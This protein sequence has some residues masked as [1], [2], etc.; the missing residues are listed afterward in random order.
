MSVLP[1]KADL[2]EHAR[3]VRF[4]PKGTVNA[5]SEYRGCL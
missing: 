3:D 2:V 4:L 5:V 1:P